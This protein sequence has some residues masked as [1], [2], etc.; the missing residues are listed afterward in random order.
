[1]HHRPR[2][3]KRR[4]SLRKV[5]TRTLLYLFL[6]VVALITLLPLVYTLLGSFKSLQDILGSAQIWPSSWHPENYVRAW[7]EANFARFFLNSVLITGGVVVFDLIASSMLGYVLARK[8]LRGQW[9]IEALLIATI[10]LGVGTITLFPKLKIA[11]SLGMLNLWGVG[12]V[13]I[14]GFAAVHVLLVKAFIRSIPNEIYEA[15]VIDGASFF[16]TYWRVALPMM[17]PILATVA[18]LGFTGSWNNFQDPFV[19][20]LTRPELRTITVGLFQLRTGGSGVNEWNIMLAGTVLG[21]VPIIVVFILL[22]RY[23]IQGLAG[24][25]VKG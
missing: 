2:S 21:I 16:G 7:N 19:F 13:Q 9:L 5:L 25:A 11:Q 10:F 17:R 22:Q 8:Q 12:A 24:G 15:A 3:K 6:T 14:A 4:P 18:V 20:T 1:M 23:F